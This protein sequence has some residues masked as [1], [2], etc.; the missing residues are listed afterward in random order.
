[1]WLAEEE[2]NVV[3]LWWNN[4][5]FGV[6]LILTSGGTLEE[7]FNLSDFFFHKTNPIY[8]LTVRINSQD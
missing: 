3:H 8:I 6:C 4:S 7:L 2:K 1:M 5:G